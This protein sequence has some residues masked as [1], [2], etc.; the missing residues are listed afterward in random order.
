MRK[1]KNDMKTSLVLKIMRGLLAL[2]LLG[3]GG[4]SGGSG[5]SDSAGGGIGGSGV[6]VGAVTAIGSVVVNG[7]E[8]DTTN[9][10]VVI[11]GNI[12]GV[13]DQAVSQHLRVGMVVV[14][15][16]TV[17]ND[18]VTGT[19]ST[20]YFDANVLGPVESIDH[21]LGQIVVL[22]Q[23]VVIDADT[24]FEGNWSLGDINPGDRV[25][26][27]GLVTVLLNGEEAIHATYVD[28][29]KTAPSTQVEVKGVV[30]N[31]DTFA[32]QT[33]KIG[34]LM[35]NY[36]D[37]DTTDLPNGKPRNAL[38]VRVTGTAD[39]GP[40]GEFLNAT[41]VEVAREAKVANAARMDVEGFVTDFTSSSQFSVGYQQV[42]TDDKTTVHGG[43]PANI[44]PG[45]KLEVKGKL[46][47]HILTA[48]KITFLD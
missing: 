6:S 16:G 45:V 19:A 18:D 44:A 25:E 48:R 34:N 26:V 15:D 1:G 22:G 37:A 4:C 8:F 9:A 32:P 42:L 47:N 12:M 40:S 33:F 14:V 31:L 39:V 38:L 21:A 20:V 29:E 23:V 24:K 5:G 17:H 30:R 13:G 3:F 7:V 41:K 43:G 11:G 10:D 28:V 27:S 46:E 35:V 36:Q 2:L